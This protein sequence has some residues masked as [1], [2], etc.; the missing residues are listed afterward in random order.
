MWAGFAGAGGILGPIISSLVVD[1][2]TWPWVFAMPVVMAAVA[3]AITA[4][5]V[6]HS[7]EHHQGRFDVVGSVLSVTGSAEE[8]DARA[9][10]LEFAE[11]TDDGALEPA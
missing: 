9:D 6:P 2:L 8:I 4:L 10:A 5:A 11:S 3:V 1:N 7:S